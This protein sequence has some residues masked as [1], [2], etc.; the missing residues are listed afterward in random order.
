MNTRKRTRKTNKNS[1]NA[2]ES[3]EESKETP[4]RQKK[5]KKPESVWRAQKH[6]K[7]PQHNLGG[8]TAK[9][10]SEAQVALL[11]VDVI[12]DLQFPGMLRFPWW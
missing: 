10:K 12:N 7:E 8:D 4:K 9:E 3:N 5:E 6:S 1:G 11:V 2:E